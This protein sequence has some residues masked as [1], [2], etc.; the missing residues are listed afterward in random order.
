MQLR[1]LRKLLL[2]V[3]RFLN[4]KNLDLT[5]RRSI[6]K[7]PVV[8]LVSKTASLLDEGIMKLA[9]REWDHRRDNKAG[10]V[11]YLVFQKTA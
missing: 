3:N 4:Y 9:R 10:S 11:Q 6:L 8:R 2:G 1:L 7:Q 5:K